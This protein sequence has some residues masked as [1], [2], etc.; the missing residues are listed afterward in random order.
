MILMT[1]I[2]RAG[3]LRSRRETRLAGP[4]V[5]DG[6]VIAGDQNG[7]SCSAGPAAP[8]GSR[9]EVLRGLAPY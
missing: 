4:P 1:G 6:P 8:E 3:R 2:H 9:G 5:V 7:M